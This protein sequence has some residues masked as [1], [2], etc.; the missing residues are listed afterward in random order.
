MPPPIK[1][2][3]NKADF[4]QPTPSQLDMSSLVSPLPEKCPTSEDMGQAALDFVQRFELHTVLGAFEEQLRDVVKE[5]RREPVVDGCP[6][7]EFGRD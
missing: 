6:A 2:S 1:S 3:G 4:A 7:V 5:R